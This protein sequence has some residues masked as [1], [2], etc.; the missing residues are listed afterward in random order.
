MS[1]INTGKVLVGGLLAGLVF[2][3]LDTVNGM[4][5]MGEDFRA[6][7]TRLNLDPA[8]M[9]SGA[10]MATWI[11]IDFLMGILVIW[12]YAAMRP[13]FGPGPKTAVLAGLACN[14][15]ITLVMFGLTQGGI[16]TM[17]I[18]AKMAVITLVITSVGAIAGAWAYKE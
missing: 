13:R 16:F 6:N 8:K 5:V 7:M 14:L 2:N 1:A 11:I 10:G 9:E 15:A 4:L 18:W 12:V 3:I 17:A